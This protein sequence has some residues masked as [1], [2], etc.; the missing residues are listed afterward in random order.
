MHSSYPTQF[1]FVFSDIIGGYFS[2]SACFGIEIMTVIDENIRDFLAIFLQLIPFDPVHFSLCIALVK[3]K[4]L[5]QHLR[6]H[7]IVFID[8]D[9]LL[10][11]LR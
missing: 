10:L 2:I 3:V 4:S 7:R 1:L 5:Q 11:R 8:I 6:L 9:L